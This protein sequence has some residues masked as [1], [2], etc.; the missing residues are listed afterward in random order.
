[1]NRYRSLN[2]GLIYDDGDDIMIHVV[3]ERKKSFIPA[4]TRVE[5]PSKLLYK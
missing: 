3:F 5:G 1:M 4:S 2:Y